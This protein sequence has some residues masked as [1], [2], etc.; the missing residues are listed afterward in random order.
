MTLEHRM[1]P[2]F[3][4]L[5]TAAALLLTASCHDLNPQSTTPYMNRTDVQEKICNGVSGTYTASLSVGYTGFR[6]DGQIDALHVVQLGSAAYIVGRHDNP[7]VVLNSF[8]VSLLSRVIAD[9]NLAALLASQA[10]ATL[11]L[12]YSIVGDG[13]ET[14]TGSIE[15]VLSPYTFTVTDAAGTSHAVTL[16]FNKTSIIAG[17]N[18]DDS[19]TWH[20]SSLNLDLRSIS[21]DGRI[22]QQ[23]G[24]L[25]SGNASFMVRYRGEKQ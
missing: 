16:S 11:T 8:P 23:F 7:F 2:V 17:I 12:P 15:T 3:T 6:A 14:H 4:V 10:N 20:L 5:F 9:P 19:T 18:A 24:A 13:P 25:H 21:V 1:R 22:V